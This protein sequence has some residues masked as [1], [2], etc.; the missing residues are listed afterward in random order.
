MF[1]IQVIELFP[2][3]NAGDVLARPVRRAQT[4]FSFVVLARGGEG[5]RA[6]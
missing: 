3:K 5:L 6:S 1:G 2:F 4:V